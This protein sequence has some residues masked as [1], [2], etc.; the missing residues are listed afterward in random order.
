MK[1]RFIGPKQRCGAHTQLTVPRLDFAGP[2]FWSCWLS[3]MQ[4]LQRSSFPLQSLKLFFFFF[5]FCH[6]LFRAKVFRIENTVSL[7]CDRSEARLCDVFTCWP[8][9]KW[10]MTTRKRKSKI[11]TRFKHPRSITF[12]LPALS[13]RFFSFTL[14]S[15]LLPRRC[16]PAERQLCH[17]H[18]QIVHAIFWAYWKC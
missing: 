16:C 9:Q 12:K 4:I 1:F 7:K 13:F 15:A 6:S 5:S 11:F 10:A 17:F 18:G 3:A 2:S 8:F 14:Q